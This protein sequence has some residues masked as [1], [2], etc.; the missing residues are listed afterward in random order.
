MDPQDFSA[1]ASGI[2]AVLLSVGIIIGG[3]WTLYRFRTLGESKRAKAELES[4][5][6]FELSL[7]GSAHESHA[8]ARFILVTASI[9]NSGSHIEFIDWARTTVQCARLERFDGD[10][11]ILSE[12]RRLTR[13]AKLGADISAVEPGEN[14]KFAFA[15][16]LEED[17]IFYV[18]FSGQRSVE[19][20]NDYRKQFAAARRS[21]S[22]TDGESYTLCGS[23]IID[24]RALPSILPTNENSPVVGAPR[25]HQCV[26]DSSRSTRD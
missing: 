3:L 9:H 1:R 6:S 17:G 16:P 14:V 26:V 20:S 23:T 12:W 13:L 15:L 2:Q 24:T 4:M 19:V 11:P 18:D 5:R 7:S 10:K 25:L 8:G 21:K 22:Q